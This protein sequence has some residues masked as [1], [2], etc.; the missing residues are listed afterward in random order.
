M[1]DEIVDTYK[2]LIKKHVIARLEFAS[3]EVTDYIMELYDEHL[4]SPVAD[5]NSR[6][7]PLYYRDGFL[8][9]LN[10]FEYIES[11]GDVINFIVPNMNNF[12]FSGRL[13]M[14][15]N[16][17]DGTAGIY[18]EVDGQQYG[19]LFPNKK[20]PIVE[21]LDRSIPKSQMIYLVKYN[22]GIGKRWSVL[23]PKK[24]MV[25][26]PF[27]NVP[28]IEIFEDANTFVDERLDKWIEE[29]TDNVSDEFE[30]LIT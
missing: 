18:I 16:I 13:K 27:S 9:K 5:V 8:E 7:N 17:M 4:V 24:R 29:A 28:P 20:P 1:A 26:F 30:T 6:S 22:Y 10:E 25:R 21:A 12:G 2:K 11:S 14:I 15:E 19:I 3:V 23:F